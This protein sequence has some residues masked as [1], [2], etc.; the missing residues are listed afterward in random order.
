M[1]GYNAV[2]GPSPSTDVESTDNWQGFCRAYSREF[3]ISYP[4]AICEAGP[5]WAEYK[6][7]HGLHFK[8]EKKDKTAREQVPLQQPRRE[9]TQESLL[10]HQR[11]QAKQLAH[12]K[13]GKRLRVDEVDDSSPRIDEEEEDTGA[14]HPYVPVIQRV[15]ASAAPPSAPKKRRRQSKGKTIDDDHSIYSNQG[16]QQPM[17]GP[18]GGWAPYYDM[19]PPGYYDG[20][21]G[22]GGGGGRGGGRMSGY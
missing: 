19:T 2:V 1:N 10:H 21:R 9:T 8:Y 4:A 16:T 13:E 17:W 5:A 6:K 22:R 11:T 15:P 7:Q 12:R 18:P 3:N 14:V 20:G